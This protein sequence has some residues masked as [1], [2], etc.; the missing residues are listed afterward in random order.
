MRVD[1]WQERDG[2]PTEQALTTKLERMGYAMSRYVYPPDTYFGPHTHD[3][4]KI[5]AVVSGRFRIEMNGETVILGPGDSIHVPRG[6]EHSAEVVGAQPV[7]S[8]D[9]V[10]RE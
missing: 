4:E 2:S 1:R 8:L 3:V 7:I 10:R 6:A 5:D 9:G